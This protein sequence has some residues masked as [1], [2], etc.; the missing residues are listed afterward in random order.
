MDDTSWFDDVVPHAAVQSCKM[1]LRNLGRSTSAV[2]ILGGLFSY[3]AHDQALADDAAEK[4]LPTG[5]PDESI[6]TSLPSNRDPAGIRQA[7]SG[8]GITFSVTYTGEVLGNPSGGFR[9]GTLYDG[10]LVVEGDID[11]EKLSGWKGLNF[12]SSFY[13][14]HGHSI[15]DENIGSIAAISNI[16]ATPASRLFEAWFEQ[17]LLGDKLTVRLGQLAADAEFLGSD[18]GRNFISSGFGWP[19]L[20]SGNIPN[21]GPIYPLATPGVR[22]KFQPND[23][24]A[25]LA[26]LYNGNPVGPCDGD[27]QVCNPH[28]LEFRLEDPPLLLLEAQYK[29]NQDKDSAF[30]PGTIK[31]G[32][33]KHFG[34]FEDQ[35]FDENG[36]SLA[37]PGSASVARRIHSDHVFYGVIDQQIYQMPGAETGKGI[38]AF[39]RAETSPSDRNEIDLAVDGGFTFTGIVPGRPDDVFGIGAVYTGLSNRA[40]DLDRDANAFNGTNAPVRDFETLVELS[41]TAKIM[42]GWNFQPDAQYYW[43]PG[44]NVADPNDPS[45]QKVVDHALVLGVRSTVSY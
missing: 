8:A 3:V 20:T 32:G 22:L 7:L 11:F 41:Y 21:G 40:S 38:A 27:P 45:G 5:I 28:G 36:I 37:D 18:G 19:T 10:L 13:Q 39:L 15:S 1:L 6:A 24:L 44:G 17:Q 26:G 16:E 4:G 9:H 14:I 12:H 33:Y 35:R 30:L 34:D 42:P 23:Q 29:Y 31:V 2:V 43:N 25:L